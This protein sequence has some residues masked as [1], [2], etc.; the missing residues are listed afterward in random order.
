MNRIFSMI[1]KCRYFYAISF[2]E[3]NKSSQVSANGKN[4]KLQGHKFHKH[5]FTTQPFCAP[6]KFTN[7]SNQIHWDLS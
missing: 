6:S 5:H 4:P 2:L 3:G 7:S 1:H